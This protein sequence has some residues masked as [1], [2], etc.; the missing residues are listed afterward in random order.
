MGPAKALPHAGDA[1]PPD[2]ARCKIS[3]CTF[4]SLSGC[5]V[6]AP[7]RSAKTS[8]WRRE[9]TTYDE[10]KSFP[11]EVKNPWFNGKAD[12]ASFSREEL[13]A[14]KLRALLQRDKGRDLVDLAKAVALFDGLDAARVVELFG[15]HLSASGQTI[16]RA[17]AEERMWAKLEDPSFLADVRPLMAPDDAEEFDS[18]AERTAFVTVF[19]EFVKR[20][21]SQAWLDTPAMAKKNEMPEL[22]KA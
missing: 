2:L 1:R 9:R 20:L 5:G 21:P 18:D 16:S 8:D 13:L 11:F 22:A 17:E 15:K 4:C 6:K 10:E 19:T 3:K 14:T 12:I 7:G